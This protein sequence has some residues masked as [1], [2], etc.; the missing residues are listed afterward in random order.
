MREPEPSD[1]ELFHEFIT[2]GNQATAM[3]YAAGILVEYLVAGARG[4]ELPSLAA[5]LAESDD[6]HYGYGLVVLS[7]NKEE[8]AEETRLKLPLLYYVVNRSERRQEKRTELGLTMPLAELQSSS[9]ELSKDATEGWSGHEE[10]GAHDWQMIGTI[11]YQAYHD[12]IPMDDITRLAIVDEL[13]PLGAALEVDEQAVKAMVLEG[14]DPSKFDTEFYGLCGRL[15]E[16]HGSPRALSLKREN[17]DDG[18]TFWFRT[19]RV[20]QLE[21][22]EYFI[23]HA[24]IQN[25]SDPKQQVSIPVMAKSQELRSPAGFEEGLLRLMA[26]ALLLAEE[27]EQKELPEGLQAGNS[28]DLRELDALEEWGELYFTLHG[29]PTLQRHARIEPEGVTDP[30]ARAAQEG[31]IAEKLGVQVNPKLREFLD[32][33]EDPEG[34]EEFLKRRGHSQ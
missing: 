7:P 24:C 13:L 22:D 8:G 26:H 31:R 20:P 21:G 12:R 27:V 29:Q 34:L 6:A 30:W 18:L 4:T 3:L 32:L 28:V 16:R 9:Q 23:V 15:F 5:A 11:L 33:E 19:I 1:E 17:V 25:T 10:L 2:N 14:A